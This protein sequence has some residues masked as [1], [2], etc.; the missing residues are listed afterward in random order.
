MNR[1]ED[2][3]MICTDPKMEGREGEMMMCKCEDDTI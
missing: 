3:R 2:E 1:C